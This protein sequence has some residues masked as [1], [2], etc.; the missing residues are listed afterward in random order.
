MRERTL[1][2]SAVLAYLLQLLIRTGLADRSPEPERGGGK[3]TT[4]VHLARWLQLQERAV[5]LAGLDRQQTSNVWL[6]AAD[7][8]SIP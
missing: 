8:F 4:A 1:S 2:V 3:S 7:G 6:A 5:H